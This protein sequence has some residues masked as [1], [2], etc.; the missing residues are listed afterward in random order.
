VLNRTELAAPL[1]VSVPTINQWLGVLETT[2][3]LLIVP[4]FYENLGKRLIKSPKVYYADSGL[5]C[6]LLGITTTAELERSPFLGALWEGFVAAEIIKQQVNEGRRRELYHF[7]D[8][9]G[10]EVD[11]LVPTPNG[12]VDMI[13]CKS[14]RTPVPGMA[15][16]L[17]QLTKAFE[18]K[19]TLARPA[20]CFIL[21]RKG[22]RRTPKSLVHGVKAMEL[23]DWM[24]HA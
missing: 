10:L 21:H 20:R 23:H 22:D 18:E 8:Q 7:R 1:G 11:F 19:R 3:Q 14:T 16:S 2:Q 4:P 13:E 15:A 12:G 24:E 5:A 6:H 17:A 9:Q